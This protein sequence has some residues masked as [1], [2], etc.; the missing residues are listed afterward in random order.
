MFS[1]AAR[2]EQ[3]SEA[4]PSTDAGARRIDAQQTAAASVRPTAAS[5]VV[6]LHLRD[7]SLLTNG[8]IQSKVR[9]QDST[10]FTF[11]YDF[12]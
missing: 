6:P 4:V 2:G 1:F 5:H 9:Q 11:N 8:Y 10:C 7:D 12:A 3:A